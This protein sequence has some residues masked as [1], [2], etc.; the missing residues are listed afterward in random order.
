MTGPRAPG[1][2]GPRC[3]LDAAGLEVQ[4]D[5]WAGL[6]AWCRRLEKGDGT[7][8]AWFDAA[9]G[10]RLAEVAEAERSCCSFLDIDVTAGPSGWRLRVVAGRPGG[11]VVVD[12]LV[13]ELVRGGAPLG[14]SDGRAG[15]VTPGT[16]ETGARGPSYPA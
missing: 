11:E 14:G 1:G 8:L 16:D 9:A 4:L 6:G 2:D 10:P 7:A 5:A 3:T 12:Q 15:P 13:A